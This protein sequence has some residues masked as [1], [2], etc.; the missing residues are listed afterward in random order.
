MAARKNNCQAMECLYYDAWHDGTFKLKGTGQVANTKV[1]VCAFDWKQN[2][3]HLG[4]K[5]N[6]MGV[7]GHYHTK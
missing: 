7:H 6:V 5:V 3:G 2:V 4:N 1:M